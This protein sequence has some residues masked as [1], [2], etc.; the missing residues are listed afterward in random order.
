MHVFLAAHF[1]IRSERVITHVCVILENIRRYPC[2]G[3]YK[4]LKYPKMY[5]RT[6]WFNGYAE[7]V[8]AHTTASDCLLGQS[9]V[10]K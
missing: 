5:R 6:C 4:I 9:L 7:H 3:V 10:A 8:A 2:M 1:E